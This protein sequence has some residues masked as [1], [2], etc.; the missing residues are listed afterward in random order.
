MPETGKRNRFFSMGDKGFDEASFLKLLENTVPE[1]VLRREESAQKKRAAL[2]KAHGEMS[3]EREAA[4]SGLRRLVTVPRVVVA[5]V[6]VA[7][8]VTSMYFLT[9]AGD[10]AYARLQVHRGEVS[11]YRSGSESP[12]VSRS[13][14]DLHENDKVVGSDGA[15]ASINTH[16]GDQTRMEGSTELSLDKLDADGKM[17]GHEAGRTYHYS[18]T[19]YSYSVVISG[20]EVKKANEGE[21]AFSTDF[22]RELARTRVIKGRV[23]IAAGSAG[24]LVISEGEEALAVVIEGEQKIEVS[25]YEPEVLEE[26]WYQ[27]NLEH[28]EKDNPGQE[29]GAQPV[30]EIEP[31]SDTAPEP[32]TAPQPEPVPET[33][34]DPGSGG[35]LALTYLCANDN[36]SDNQI[37]PRFKISNNGGDSVPLSEL[38]IRYW[39]TVDGE[40]PQNF[41]CDWARVGSGNVLGDFHKLSSPLSGADYYLEVSFAPGA[42]S[43]VSGEDSGEVQCRFSKSDW[44]NYNESGDYSHNA[45][46]ASFTETSKIT[47][48]RNGVLIWGTEP[49]GKTPHD[50]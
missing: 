35:D 49:G 11:I 41:W 23:A 32:D 17:F 46:A 2:V 8:L 14:F 31:I 22:D 13:E 16:E 34:P 44:T 39:Y 12:I 6:M 30:Y 10:K 29:D 21:C 7:A 3:T 24:T 20:I 26:S 28:D 42:G 33:E 5:M 9:L 25:R 45:A 47:L 38:T 43:L 48:Y 27:W 50:R 19:N 40:R 4:R 18:S 1:H 15:L 36:S 37:M